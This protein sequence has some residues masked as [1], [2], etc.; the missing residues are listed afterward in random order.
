MKLFDGKIFYIASSFLAGFAVMTVELISGRIVAPII[1]ASVFT[2]TSVIGITLLG[3]A[4]GSYV[5]GQIADKTK[6]D[7]SLPLAFLASSI[8]VALIPLLAKNTNFITNS[9]DSILRL[10]LYLSI[11]LF[12]LPTFAIGLI[13]PII[14]KKFADD[15]SK[16]GSEYGTLSFAWSAG[17]ILGVFLTGFFFISYIGS[18]ETIWLMS[19]ILFLVGIIFAFKDK[20]I[21]LFFILALAVIPIQGQLMQSKTSNSSIIFQKETNYY[22]VKVVDTILPMYGDAR[23]LALDFDF[24]SIEPLGS[25]RE[26]NEIQ[27]YPETY[28]IFSNLKKDIKSI[29]LIGAGAY[30]MPKYFKDYYKDASVSVVEIDPEMVNIGKDFFDLGKYDIK[31]II[32]DA[33]VVLNKSKEKYDVIFGDSYNS[34][35]SVPWYLL[36]EEWNNKVREKLNDGGIYAVNFIGSTEGEKSGFMRSV[37]RTFKVAFPNFYVF[38]LGNNGEETQNVILVGMKG[39]LPLSEKDLRAKL[40]AGKNSFLAEKIVPAQFFQDSSGIILTDNFSP[41][42]KLMEPTIKDYFSKSLLELQ[43]I[44]TI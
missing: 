21:F 24:H 40:S 12:L 18:K 27:D 34:F 28:P 31:T 9:S 13:Q 3:L 5:G 1:G 2:W 41:V 19:L 42:E 36:T 43:S 10:N 25:P 29:L 37:L 38:A 17:G 22:D 26:E 16:I 39:D 7:R 20:K 32:G 30:T 15:F 44:L 8:L 33:K 14:L 6:I 35:I 4:L 23:I 11:Y